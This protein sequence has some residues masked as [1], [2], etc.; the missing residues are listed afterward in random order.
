MRGARASSIEYASTSPVRKSSGRSSGCTWP[1]GEKGASSCAQCSSGRSVGTGSGAVSSSSALLPR[2]YRK[3][4]GEVQD[5]SEKEGVQQVRRLE[6]HVEDGL[7]GGAAEVEEA[8]RGE[9]LSE[10][11][12]RVDQGRHQHERAEDELD[13]PDDPPEA[14]H[15]Q[16]REQLLA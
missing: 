10:G 3:V 2:A 9:G 11:V 6:Q 14:L 1:S 5:R 15:L 12:M 13:C 8:R 16:H 4:P 7:V